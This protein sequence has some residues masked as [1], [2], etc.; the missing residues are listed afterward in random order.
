M[1]GVFTV[2]LGESCSRDDKTFLGSHRQKGPHKDHLAKWLAL[3]T[4]LA[5][6]I[7]SQIVLPAY[8]L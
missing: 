4:T 8:S 6:L 2:T 5:C 3:R 1:L 7:G